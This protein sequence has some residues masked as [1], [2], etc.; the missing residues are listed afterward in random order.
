MSQLI[1]NQGKTGVIGGPKCRQ[2]WTFLK[3]L[4]GLHF[5]QIDFF[6][7]KV[8]W[9]IYRIRWENKNFDD[10][11]THH[12]NSEIQN[13][14]VSKQRTLSSWKV[15]DRYK[16]TV[17]PLMSDEDKTFNGSLVLDMRFW[18][19]HMHTLYIKGFH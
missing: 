9:V 14:L 15:V 4:K 5:I 10:L 11:G 6:F 13:V 8:H 7:I 3:L 2:I 12:H 18:W 16:S 19:S 1:P 17:I